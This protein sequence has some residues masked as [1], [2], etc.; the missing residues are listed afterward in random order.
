M[1]QLVETIAGNWYRYDSV[2]ACIATL[3]LFAAFL[4]IDIESDRISRIITMVAPAT[5]GVYLIHAH[6]E[7][8]PWSWEVL[9][10][11]VKM[12]SVLFCLIQVGVVLAIY[13]GCTV[14][15]LI[16]MKT[17]GRVESS[18]MIV[19]VCERISKKYESFSYKW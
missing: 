11:P 10:L 3:C 17:V 7:F 6:A 15:D 5:L 13:I 4:N 14:L 1:L 18:K 8:S 12:D 9:N 16:R 2:P 19:E